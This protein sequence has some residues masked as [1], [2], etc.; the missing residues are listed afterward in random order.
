MHTPSQQLQRFAVKSI[1]IVSQVF[2]SLQW[3]VLWDYRKV[4]RLICECT[5]GCWKWQQFCQHNCRSCEYE[6]ERLEQ[7]LKNLRSRLTQ[8]WQ[9]SHAR[10]SIF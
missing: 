4:G 8:H 5:C 6:V 9:V 3:S 7:K 10:E 2:C 1:G